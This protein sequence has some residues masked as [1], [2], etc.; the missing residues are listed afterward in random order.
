MS[1]G[2]HGS[3]NVQAR[4]IRRMLL[5]G[6]QLL[7]ARS[8][9]EIFQQEGEIALSGHRFWFRL[10]HPHSLVHFGFK[11]TPVSSQLL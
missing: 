4:A 10:H 1:Q 8:F 2:P 3:D 7:E 6:C 5:C 9:Q 11:N